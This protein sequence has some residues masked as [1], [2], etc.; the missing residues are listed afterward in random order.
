DVQA[1]D[2]YNVQ[3][4]LALE[5]RLDG[6]RL[7]RAAQALIERHASL[8]ACFVHAPSSKP[9]QLIIAGVKTVWRSIDLSAV[10]EAQHETQLAEIL[11]QDRARRF[12]VGAAPLLRFTLIRLFDAE[13]RL[14]ISHHHLLMDGWS[15]PVLVGELLT[16]YERDGQA[17]TLPP[18]TP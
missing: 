18:V 6:D 15:G 11:K 7:Q 8:R 5:G 16:L 12:D 10:S 4:V 9:A 3:Q 13:N 2:V 1:M 17:A 14:I